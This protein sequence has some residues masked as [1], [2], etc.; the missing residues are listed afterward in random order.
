MCTKITFKT[1]KQ[2]EECRALKSEIKSLCVPSCSSA[3]FSAQTGEF[4]S[5]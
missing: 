1:E 3:L 5:F 4:A 2:E